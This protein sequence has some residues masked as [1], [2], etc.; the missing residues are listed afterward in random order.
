MKEDNCMI[1]VY[2]NKKGEPC[3][4]YPSDWSGEKAFKEICELC[5]TLKENLDE[6][7]TQIALL[8][9]TNNINAEREIKHHEI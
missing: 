8:K 5:C 6:A 1:S 4:H 7:Q 9:K 3:F 2:R